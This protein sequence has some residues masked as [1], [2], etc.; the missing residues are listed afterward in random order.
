MS[1][2]DFFS[3]TLNVA[4][5]QSCFF[6]NRKFQFQICGYTQFLIQEHHELSQVFRGLHKWSDSKKQH[7]LN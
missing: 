7:M 4:R 1:K 6:L 3:H 5:N 2:Y